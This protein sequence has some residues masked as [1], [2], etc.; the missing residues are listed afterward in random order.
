MHTDAEV[1][2]AGFRKRR[3]GFGQGI[4]SLHGTPDGIHSTPKLREH[5]VAS[6]V[7][8]TAS[9]GRNQPIQDFPPRGKRIEGSNLI[10]SHAP[11]VALTVTS[12]NISQA[13][14][15]F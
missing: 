8:D 14:L 2:V 4:L 5:A 11:A 12:K 7:G 3:V 15:P 10:G 13:A 9:M 1:D 6:G